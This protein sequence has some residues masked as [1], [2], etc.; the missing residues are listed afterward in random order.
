[1]PGATYASDVII[2]FAAAISA[3]NEKSFIDSTIW[4]SANLAVKINL[5][6]LS[7]VCGLLLPAAD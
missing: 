6:T 2:A 4:T 5:R 7:K 1:M 3:A